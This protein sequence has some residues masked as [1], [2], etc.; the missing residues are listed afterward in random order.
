MAKKNNTQNKKPSFLQRVKFIA[1]NPTLRFMLGLLMGA[2]AIFLCSSFL[3]FFS[4]GG[5]DQSTIDAAAAAVADADA[6][7]QNTSGRGGAIVAD[8]LVNGCFGWSSVLLIPLFVG[9][10]LRLMDIYR[11]LWHCVGFGVLCVCAWLSL[12][13]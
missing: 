12:R 11:A 7:V 6:S 1:A 4:S 9:A 3:S 13:G 8:Y 2:V 5:A 10:M